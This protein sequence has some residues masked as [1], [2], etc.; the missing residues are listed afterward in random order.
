MFLTT[1]GDGLEGKLTD[2]EGV[3]VTDSN[4]FKT[5]GNLLA[6]DD[7]VPDF[8][9]N[10]PMDFAQVAMAIKNDASL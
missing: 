8:D 10:K 7:D 3:L 6:N 5:E 2:K 4:Q 9:P 1:L